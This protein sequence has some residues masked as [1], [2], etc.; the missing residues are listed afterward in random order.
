MTPV[1]DPDLQ[2]REEGEGAG[3]SQKQFCSALRASVW[4]KNKGGKG[5]YPGSTTEILLSLIFA[6]ETSAAQEWKVM[7]VWIPLQG[8]VQ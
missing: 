5:P 6:S 4:S 1:A 2:I 3:W 8:S 7:K